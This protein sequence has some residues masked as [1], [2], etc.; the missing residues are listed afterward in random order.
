MSGKARNILLAAGVL[1][2]AS[3]VTVVADPLGWFSLANFEWTGSDL[4]SRV[5]FSIGAWKDG[6]AEFVVEPIGESPPLE[7]IPHSGEVWINE[8]VYQFGERE[9][10]AGRKVLYASIPVGGLPLATGFAFEM[11]VYNAAG[12]QLLHRSTGYFPEQN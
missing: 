4:K 7:N 11:W 5:N 12:E 9:I 8:K 3:A 10:E 1:L 6:S 2:S